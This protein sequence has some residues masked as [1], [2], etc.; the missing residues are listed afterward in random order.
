MSGW[1]YLNGSDAL[2]SSS[3]GREG[4]IAK[5]EDSPA[6]SNVDDAITVII[7]NEALMMTLTSDNGRGY[8]M[9]YCSQCVSSEGDR[10]G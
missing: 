2:C 6:S 8:R 3:E 9:E 4:R 5:P 7:K 1:T 10:V